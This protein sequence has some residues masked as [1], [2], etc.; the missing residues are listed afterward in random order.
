MVVSHPSKAETC[1]LVS[2][3][4]VRFTYTNYSDFGGCLLAF[5]WRRQRRSQ[6]EEVSLLRRVELAILNE[7]DDL[8]TEL[9]PGLVEVVD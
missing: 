3:P 1:L 4:S 2:F 7:R 9:S 5:K 6:E 8:P